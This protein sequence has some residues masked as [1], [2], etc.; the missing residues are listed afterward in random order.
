MRPRSSRPLLCALAAAAFGVAALPAQARPTTRVIATSGQAVAGTGGRV[1]RPSLNPTLNDAGEVAFST[2]FEDGREGILLAGSAG[3]RPIGLAGQPIPDGTATLEDPGLGLINARGDVAFLSTLRGSPRA[4]DRALFLAPASAGGMLQQVAREDD[5]QPRGGSLRLPQTPFL[6]DR[7][8]LLTVEPASTDPTGYTLFRGGTAST[9]VRLGDPAPVSGLPLQRL[10]QPRFNN[11]GQIAAYA[12]AASS[13]DFRLQEAGIYRFESG[14]PGASAGT[15]ARIV[16]V[17]QDDPSAAGRIS[18]VSRDEL[19]MNA[20]GQVA[21]TASVVGHEDPDV[22]TSTRGAV[23]RGDGADLQAIARV[24]ERTTDTDLRV[25]LASFSDINASGDVLLGAV[26][27]D[28][29]SAGVNPRNALL[30]GDGETLRTA[31]LAGDAAPDGN[32][33]LDRVEF[34]GSLDDLGG[35]AFASTLSG[36]RGGGADDRGLF[37]AAADGR[38][39]QVAREGDPLAG[40]TIREVFGPGVLNDAGRIAFP[41]RIQ[42]GR[43]GLALWTIPEPGVLGLLLLALAAPGR[44][45]RG[46]GQGCPLRSPQASASDPAP[47]VGT[48]RS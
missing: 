38:L 27:S 5:P 3:L 19:G 39:L 11:A 28:G 13:E 1:A 17:D 2:T 43:D 20:A 47:V 25:D 16:R 32:G 41:F 18:F 4:R 10:N 34:R 46:V 37:Y 48:R 33:V 14:A 29:R 45:L 7:G 31:A 12:E 35:V 30:V 24:G 9:P 36:T 8:D 21:F 26:A 40:S 44:R 6:N 23:F 22:F 42:D 15:G